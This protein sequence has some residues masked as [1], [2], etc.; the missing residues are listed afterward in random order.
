MWK[1]NVGKMF[2]YS[3]RLVAVVGGAF[4]LLL[5]LAA[6]AAAGVVPVPMGSSTAGATITYG[7]AAAVALEASAE[8]PATAQTEAPADT[9][10][11][12]PATTVPD[13]RATTTVAPE[14]EP[15]PEPAPA[16]APPATTATPK[17]AAR[18]NV[19]SAQVQTAIGQ[20]RARN[21]LFNVTEDQARQFGDMVCDAFDGGSSYS[22]VRAQVLQAVSGHPLL[23]VT[24]A[25]ADFAIRTSVKL[26][27]PSHTS[28]L[29]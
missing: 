19:S 29:Q 4:G 24:A 25:D 7:A 5:L 8:A 22:Q 21:G 10:P 6:G 18:P 28:K 27:C 23:T 20:L 14:P 26:F 1:V 9:P 16:P 2:Q 3:T 17:T 15:E 11:P 13:P 12:T